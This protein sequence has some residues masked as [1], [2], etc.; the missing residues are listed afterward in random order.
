MHNANIHQVLQDL[1]GRDLLG[2][3]AGHRIA[4]RLTAAAGNLCAT[5]SNC[6]NCIVQCRN[7]IVASRL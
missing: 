5:P 1:A 4:A 7:E 6:L 3:S 2:G